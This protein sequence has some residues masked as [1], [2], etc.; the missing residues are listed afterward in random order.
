MSRHPKKKVLTVSVLK[1]LDDGDSNSNAIE[2]AGLSVRSQWYLGVD[3][4]TTA[5]AASLLNAKTGQQHAIVWV[6]NTP[7][8]QLSLAVLPTVVGLLHSFKPYLNSAIPYRSEVTQQWEPLVLRFPSELWNESLPQSIPLVHIQHHLSTLLATLIVGD[9]NG[10]SDV[11][12]NVTCIAEGLEDSI[13]QVALQQL[14]GVVVNHPVGAS[15]AYRFNLREAVLA[16]GL[17]DQPETVF[18]IEEAIAALLAELHPL[19]EF[20]TGATVLQPPSLLQG[21]VLVV[22]AGATTTELALRDFQKTNNSRLVE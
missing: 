16:A 12:S 1:D 14:A 21:E 7:E 18:F 15:D 2:V 6:K 20:T 8:G 4:G 9:F 22:S 17:V 10:N 5:L 3:V 11:N 19:A 13:F